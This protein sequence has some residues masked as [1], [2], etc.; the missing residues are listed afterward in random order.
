MIDFY[1]QHLTTLQHTTGLSRE[2]LE[3]LFGVRVHV[4]IDPALVANRTHA[5]TFAA[6]ITMLTR[7]FP[8]TTFDVHANS[9]TFLI[10]PWG[11]GS[12]PA[13]DGPASVSVL[14]GSGAADVAGYGANWQVQVNVG[15]APNPAEP[16]NPVLA[17]VTACY[18]AA[19]TSKAVFEDRLDGASRFGPFSILHFETATAPFD[20]D[21]PFDIGTVHLGGVGAIGTAWLYALAAHGTAVGELLPADHDVLDWT[22]LGRYVFFDADDVGDPKVDRAER[23][24]AALLPRLNVR[25]IP[26]RLEAYVERTYVADSTF[27]IQHLVSCPDQRSTRRQW[28]MLLPRNLY[29]AS[30]GPSEVVLHANAFDREFACAVCIYPEHAQEHAHAQHVADMLN[31]S[32][33]RIR[34]GDSISADDAGA[35][36]QRYPR[37]ELDDLIGRAFDSVFRR[38]CGASELRV[39]DQVVLSPLPFTS[40]LA[41]ALLYLEFVKR[42]HPEVFGAPTANYARLSSTRTPNPAFRQLR[43]STPSCRCQETAVRA[44]FERLWPSRDAA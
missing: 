17:I 14:I 22:N 4:A 31:V 24:L 39:G 15:G 1:E 30:T 8:R 41:G 36:R 18:I 29:D 25:P 34:S 28:Q 35:I 12:R 2:V 9:H 23:R 5:L 27:R 16:W 3:P 10:L 13:V 38:L 6:V 26:E 44:L 43:A 11:S 40:V 37:L 7:L 21:A 42:R 20:W 19:A 32:L 33:D